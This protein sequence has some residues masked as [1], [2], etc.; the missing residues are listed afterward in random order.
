VSWG[1]NL[2]FKHL[3]SAEK[4]KRILAVLTF[5]WEGQYY[6]IVTDLLKALSYGANG[7]NRG[8]VFSVRSVPR[9]YKQDN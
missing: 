8:A 7:Y 4:F 1:F 6:D 5:Y 2:A 3:Y 9:Y